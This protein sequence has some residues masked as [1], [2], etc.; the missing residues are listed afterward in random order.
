MRFI[1]N[2]GFGNKSS[3]IKS[4]VSGVRKVHQII[5]LATRKKTGVAKYRGGCITF[6]NEYDSINKRVV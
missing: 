5:R 3:C 6:S 1:R 2:K 4:N